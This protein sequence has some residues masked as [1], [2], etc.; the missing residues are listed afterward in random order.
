MKKISICTVCMNRLSH[1]RE[2]LPA[3][4]ADNMHFP[5]IEFIV[6]DYNSGDGMEKWAKSNMLPYIKSGILKY[7]KTIEPVYFHLSHSKNMALKLST[8][9]ICGLVDA[10][11]YAGPN[12]GEWVVS[13]FARHGENTILTTL[14]KNN[15][16]LRDQG[17]KLSFSRKLL[18]AVSGFDESLIGY[19]IDDVDLVNRLEMVGG[20]R[21]FIENKSFLKF[22]GHSAT[23][24]LKNHHLINNLE[25]IYLEVSD[26]MKDKNRV[27]YLLKGDSF[28]EV[29]YEFDARLEP[30]NVISYGGW[31][32][33]KNAYREGSV[34]RSSGEMALISG[35]R[36]RDVYREESSDM[37]ST[38]SN[39][40][41][42][43]WKKVP[44]EDE[45]FVNLVMGYGEC[46]N[47]LKYLENEINMK[48]VNPDGW[49]RGTVYLNFDMSNPIRIS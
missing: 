15:I 22:I 28:I 39:G 29:F 37:L 48:S 18:D 7:Y 33:Q 30:N 9:E 1:L 41:K 49:G 26:F 43:Y 34:E 27:L 3:N 25:D 10:D 6:L 46:K 21:V 17:G 24:R 5:G 8:G 42:V 36:P 47:R 35:D 32:T 2:T 38:Q 20:K 44:R 31:T 45:L 16:P 14:R 13:S 11:N 4:I 19:G 23:E 40:D 12:Y